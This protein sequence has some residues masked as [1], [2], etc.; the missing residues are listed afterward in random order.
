MSDGTPTK[1]VSIIAFLKRRPGLTHEQFYHHWVNVHGPLV[2]PWAKKHGFLEYRQIHLYPALNANRAVVGPEIAGRNT[3]LENWDGCAI[4]ELESLEK[5]EA[6]FQDPYY[7]DL[8]AK[9]EEAFV[10]K[11][12]G[13]MRRRG[14]LN[15]II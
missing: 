5:F 2:V 7:K 9:D 3:E 1:T 14:E 6:A 11:A 10:D 12:A 4:F 8:I 15:R 13:V